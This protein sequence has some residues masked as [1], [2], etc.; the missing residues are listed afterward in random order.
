ML[1]NKILKNKNYIIYMHIIFIVFCMSEE[2]KNKILELLPEEGS[3]NTKIDRFSIGRRNKS[4]I[5]ERCFYK[6]MIALMIQGNKNCV[7]NSSTITCKEGQY[8]IVGVDLPSRTFLNNVS[9]KH[10]MLAVS[11]TID[12]NIVSEISS[13]IKINVDRQYN[14]IEVDEIS[15]QLYDAFSR[16]IDIVK[17]NKQNDFITK[18]IIQEIY[19]IIL[20]SPI[21]GK[22][23]DLN[24]I[25]TS[26][27]KISNAIMTIKNNF[28]K[29]LNVNDLAKSVSMSPTNFYRNFKNI[30]GFSPLQYQKQLKLHEARNLIVVS[31]DSATNAAY[32]VGYESISQ[33]NR[34][35]KRMFGITPYKNKRAIN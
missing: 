24:T 26:N 34:E 17:Q 30:T 7:I 20:T 32:A 29:Q 1:I 8:M 22:L 31:G 4:S 2:L 28:N 5:F 14:C 13:K 11:L 9:E 23:I 10:P 18:L 27:N 33:F 19:Y 15:Q 3:Y 6:P 25:G 21:G 12:W 16:L 35:Y